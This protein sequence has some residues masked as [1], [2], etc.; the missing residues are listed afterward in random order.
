M[1][2]T[3]Y[4]AKTRYASKPATPEQQLAAAIKRAKESNITVAGS[5]TLA[6]GRRFWIVASQSVEGM[7]HVVSEHGK[8]LECDCFYDRMQH[9]ICAHRAAVFLH[10]Q[11]VAA[12]AKASPTMSAIADAAVQQAAAPAPAIKPTK[13]NALP[14]SA[15]APAPKASPVAGTPA[16]MWKS[17]NHDGE[18]I[19]R[20][21]YQHAY[22]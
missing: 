7:H 2:N 16:Y 5:G 13:E 15:T 9:K 11:A 17:E 21:H 3:S 22:R 19:S 4:R 1:P 14:A 18:Y 20:D 6:D 12:T 8:H 10:L